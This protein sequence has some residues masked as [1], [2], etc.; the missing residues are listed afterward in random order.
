VTTLDTTAVTGDKAGYFGLGLATL[1]RQAGFTLS[2]T[3]RVANESHISGNRAG[4]SLIALS[5][6]KQG[7]EL[8][9]WQDQVWA[10]NVG[11]TRGENSAFDTSSALV[12]Y[13][14]VVSGSG[15]ALSA[16]GEPL[17][18]GALRDYSAFGA[19]M[20]S[21]TFSSSVTTPLP[22]RP[23]RA[24]APGGDCRARARF[25]RASGLSVIVVGARAAKRR[26]QKSARIPAQ[27]Q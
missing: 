25:A 26:G 18:N 1:D 22:P 19:P 14:L 7:I 12:R 24:V 2:L 6:D 16:G 13:D 27:T 3:V 20:I 15:Y 5:T 10:Q 8:G 17:L 4:F 9:F 23:D 21:P 11:F